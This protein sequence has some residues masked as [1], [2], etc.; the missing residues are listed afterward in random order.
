MVFFS[1]AIIPLSQL[2]GWMQDIGRFTP[3]SQGVV[4][5][6]AVMIDGQTSFPLDG[7]GGIVWMV[8]ISA[9]YLVIGIAAFGLGEAR[10]RRWGSLGRY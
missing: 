6:R 5:P 3:I 4:G 7:D 1:G 2:P 10:A 9:A 8:A